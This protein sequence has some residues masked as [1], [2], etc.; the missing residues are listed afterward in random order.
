MPDIVEKLGLSVEELSDFTTV[1]ARKQALKMRV[2]R[3][4]FRL[5]VN[6]LDQ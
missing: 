1:C 5:S 2:W 6:P 3:V 4:L